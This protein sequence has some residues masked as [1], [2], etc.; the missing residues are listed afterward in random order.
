MAL[1]AHYPLNHDNKNYGISNVPYDDTGTTFIKGG[2]IGK[3]YYQKK[4]GVQPS[5]YMEELDGARQFSFG[6]WI[7]FDKDNANWSKAITLG[8]RKSDGSNGDIIRM[9]NAYTSDATKSQFGIYNSSNY[10][11]LEENLGACGVKTLYEEWHHFMFTTDGI[12]CRFYKDGIKIGE[13]NNIG[14]YLSGYVYFGS[15]NANTS[16]CNCKLNDIRIYNHC[17]SDSEIKEI[18]KTPILKYSFDYPLTDPVISTASDPNMTWGVV[19]NNCANMGKIIYDKEYV[20]D[21][22]CFTI[23]FD[24]EIKDIVGVDG[25]KAAM[26]IQDNTI[27][28]GETSSKWSTI[29]NT[30]EIYGRANQFASNDGTREIDL[31][32]NGTYHICRT[33]KITN[34]SRFKQNWNIQIRTDNIT[35]GV[36]KVSNFRVVLGKKEIPYDGTDGIIY[37]ESGMGND[38]VLTADNKFS[39][40]SYSNDSKIGEG[41][42]MSKTKDVDNAS[43]Y[44]YIK[45]DKIF[46]EVPEISIAF[47]LYVPKQ[48]IS[49]GDNT[50]LGCSGGSDNWDIWIYRQG[51]TLVA[52]MYH[53]AQLREA[54]LEREKWQYISITAQKNGSI[55]MYVNGEL[56][57]TKD[58]IV[59]SDWADAYLTIGD[60]RAGRGLS[61]DGKMDDLRIYATELNDEEI[62]RMYK[63]RARVD[64]KGNLYCNELVE[65]PYKIDSIRSDGNQYIDTEIIPDQD[66]TSNIKIEMKVG[67][68]EV[69]DHYAAFYGSRSNNLFQFWS[70]VDRDVQNKINVRYSGRG[71]QT[72]TVD[73]EKPLVIAQE[74]NGFYINGDKVVTHSGRFH[75][76]YNIYLFNVNNNGAPQSEGYGIRMD[77]YYCKMW[78]N[79]EIVRDFIPAISNEVGHMNEVC[80]YDLVTNRYFYNLSGAG[81]FVMNEPHLD[82]LATDEVKINEKGI[83]NCA[84]LNEGKSIAKIIHKNSI[85]ETNQINE[86]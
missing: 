28:N 30:N 71:F 3:C 45:T 81:E 70:Y 69:P 56:I 57:K 83:V 41:C 73:L 66:S 59:G 80:L 82:M 32:Q 2:K 76:S 74:Q 65:V 84:I 63:E 13:C 25:A 14:G 10:S 64:S 61:F 86:N 67:N 50:I 46:N 21:D 17:L 37:D 51:T 33:Y 29:I 72:G 36:A 79:D 23:S 77:L 75:N 34:T 43:C 5:Y 11:I 31:R 35:N 49:T 8:T 58:N 68:I 55:K 19:T 62:S 52:N 24:I 40:T 44:G 47:W 16:S 1:V 85:F 60:L 20:I 22:Q 4:T 42:Y 7:N 78:K 38:G 6:M 39:V 48:D 12:L 9:E 53:I 54:I 26:G 27:L 18:Y 15:S